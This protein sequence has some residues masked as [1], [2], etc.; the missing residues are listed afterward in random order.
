MAELMLGTFDVDF[1][2]WNCRDIT[3]K[4]AFTFHVVNLGSIPRILYA[5]DNPQTPRS[6]S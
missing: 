6:N 5:W 2:V 1:D 3:A 4:K